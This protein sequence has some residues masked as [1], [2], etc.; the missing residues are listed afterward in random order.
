VAKD[1]SG[2]RRSK[3]KAA[4]DPEG[5]MTLVE[6]LRELRNRIF[7]SFVV[8]FLGSIVGWVFYDQI[9][10]FIAK[11]LVD[12][13]DQ[14]A[15]EGH[16]RPIL[17]LTGV[18]DAFNLKL[19]VSLA[20]GIILTSPIWIY[21]LLRFITPG[22]HKNERRWAAVFGGAAVPLFLAGVAVAYIALPHVLGAFLGFTPSQANNIIDV[23]SYVGF[24]LQVSISFGLGFLAPV[25]VVALN[26]I[27][28]L[29]AQRFASW[30]RWVLF[31]ILVFAAV[32]TPTPD[33]F[34]MLLFA[35]P[36]LVLMLVAFAIC[37]LNDRRRASRAAR[38][39]F[40][41]L[42]DDEIS[43]LDL[44]V[45]PIGSFEETTTDA[46]P[47]GQSREPVDPT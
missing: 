24:L 13:A 2:R 18:A 34:N 28:V 39:D 5:R 41:H 7:W 12:A 32:A 1:E 19:Q 21:Q 40:A 44:T 45:E 33:P 47:P 16:K 30:W 35:L 37:W 26:A 4:R 31:F 6:H 8:I 36:L 46:P 3:S 29:S 43:P 20:A 15:A 9:F 38:S 10:T 27:G 14:L 42:S 23:E 25:V 22:L 17:S 11:P